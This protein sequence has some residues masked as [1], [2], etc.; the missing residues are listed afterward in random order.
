MLV[1]PAASLHRFSAIERLDHR[2]AL[3]CDRLGGFPVLLSESR[4]RD[5]QQAERCYSDIH[6]CF[7]KIEAP[8]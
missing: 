7:S 2:R 6:L 5:E 3:R 4:G 1:L 8:I